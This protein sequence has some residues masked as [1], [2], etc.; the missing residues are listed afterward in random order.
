MVSSLL[1]D[2]K[3]PLSSITLGFFQDIGYTVDFSVADP[4][5]VV[6]LFGGDR[7][8]PIPEG[9]LRNDF[10]VRRPPTFVSPLAAP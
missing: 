10:V 5:E 3:S 6:P 9:S 7:R 4:Y 8:I 2:Y 1:P